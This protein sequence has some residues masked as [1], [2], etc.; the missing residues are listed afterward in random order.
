MPRFETVG[1]QRLYD[2]T[3]SHAPGATWCVLQRLRCCAHSG[4]S[5]KTPLKHPSYK[6]HLMG[7][8]AGEGNCQLRVHLRDPTPA[9][10]VVH[11]GHGQHHPQ[12]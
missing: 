7:A 8:A 12:Q 2:Y 11:L 1:I 5:Q 4:K 9:L 10:V 6:M 3:Q